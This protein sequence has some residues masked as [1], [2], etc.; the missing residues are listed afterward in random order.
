MDAF[1]SGLSHPVVAVVLLLGIL[2]FFHEAGHFLIGKLC[3]ISV[4]IFSIGFGPVLFGFKRGETEYRLSVIPLGGFVKFY[5][6][7]PGEDVPTDL[8]GK[9]FSKASV[10]E[11]LATVLAGPLANFLLAILCFA[12]LGFHGVEHP[13]PLVGEIMLGS[14]AERAGLKFGDVVL[15]IDN[16]KIRTWADLHDYIF[17]SPGKELFFK[18]DRNGH[19][20]DVKVF[21]DA[22]EGEPPF[23]GKYGRIGISPGRVPA[24][25][26]VPQHE[27]P[28][29]RSGLR[30]GDT[31]VGVEIGAQQIKISYWRQLQN[32]LTDALAKGELVARLKVQRSIGEPEFAVEIPLQRTDFESLGLQDSQR[33]IEAI[34]DFPSRSLI[35][36]GD[37]ILKFDGHEITDIFE[38]SRVVG[39]NIKKVVP[40]TVLRD[41][42]EKTLELELK[43]VEVQRVEGKVVVYIL[44]VDFLG[45]MVSP[46]PVLEKYGLF[47]S[48]GYGVAETWAKTEM[49]AGAIFRLFTGDMP[50][51][52][53]GGPISIAK[54][55]SDSV[56][57]GWMTF[58]SAMALVSINLGLLNLVPI[59]VLDGGQI[60]LLGVEGVRRRPLPQSAVENFQKVGFVMVLGLVAMATYND[61]SR[62]WTSMLASV[63]G[64]FHE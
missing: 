23:K 41:G 62:F 50:L 52:A 60:L 20:V 5:G 30:T 2:V 12:A 45:K 21:T 13:P 49:I 8:K 26:T 63:T 17:K 27:T 48:I 51:K 19:S 24:I 58:L 44:P 39:D 28:A 31:I 64:M 47:G 46:D 35:K 14:P 22:V 53:L 7:M 57:L 61:F 42:I 40:V 54:V 34:N 4:E 9:A 32:I 56:K 15:K 38:Y 25:V 33:T 1:F 10:K 36:S 37:Q 11:R 59:P 16:E 6:S 55:A 3:G 18:V 29:G 43:P